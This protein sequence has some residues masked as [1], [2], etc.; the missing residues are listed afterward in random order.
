VA[1][2]AT[3]N[4]LLS[5]LG[6]LGWPLFLGGWATFVYFLLVYKGPL[7]HE[8]LLRYTAGHPI[9]MIE[10]G[11]FFIGLASLCCKLFT[12]SGEIKSSAAISL[13]DT[14]DGQSTE[15]ACQEILSK[16]DVLPPRAQATYLGRRIRSVVQTV[17]RRGL[18]DGIDEDLRYHADLD[19]GSQQDS[20]G[21]V[22]IAIWAIP[23]LGFLGT[24]VGITIALG[25]FANQ[26]GDGAGEDLS[27]SMKGLLGGL[28]VAFDT[29]ALALAL[30]MFMMFCQFILERME[31]QLLASVDDRAASELAG[32]FE[33]LGAAR[34]PVVASVSRMSAALVRSIES[35][36]EQQAQVW[37][38]TVEETGRIFSDSLCTSLDRSLSVFSDSLGRHEQSAMEHLQSRLG[39]W[40]AALE[41]NA[42]LLAAQ[43]NEILR[44]SE[45][46]AQVA[47]ATGDVAK[48]E[49]VLNR[50]LESLAGSKNFE[51]TV[52]S[53]SAAIQLLSTR[54][55]QAGPTTVE[56]PSSKKQRDK[57]A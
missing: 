22:R 5:S 52:M 42:V 37:R 47:I 19:V 21:M 10:V 2:K 26:I 32:R 28:Y 53:L 43:Q 35:L 46:L 56:L 25:D 11:L 51:D 38:A 4:T 40:Q 36:G 55:R 27:N 45:L 57:A 50:N 31:S 9:N 29:T 17:A 54:L 24:V 30:S 23:M 44:Q 20:Y 3:R 16:L 34:D 7:K 13:P 14:A 33:Q 1:Q 8:F 12:L 6:S 39:N 15:E 18:A 49:T 48:L 41:Q